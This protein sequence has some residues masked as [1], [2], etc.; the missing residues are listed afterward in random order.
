MRCGIYKIECVKSGT[1]YIGSSKGIEGRW[2][3]HRRGLA[4]GTHHNT[5]L[6]AEW[7]EQGDR[8]FLWSVIEEVDAESL[9]TREQYWIDY[10]RSISKVPV[11]NIQGASADKDSVGFDKKEAFYEIP[12]ERLP[13]VWPWQA[14]HRCE[15]S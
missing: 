8:Q 10:F 11:M 12:P 6:Q 7:T 9:K 2:K 15:G 14:C 3:V 4:K 1:I 13:G 5:G